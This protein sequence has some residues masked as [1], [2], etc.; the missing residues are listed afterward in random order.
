MVARFQYKKT[1]YYATIGYILAI[2]TFRISDVIIAYHKGLKMVTSNSSGKSGHQSPPIVARLKEETKDCHSRIEALP[3]FNALSEHKLPLECYVNQLRALAVVHGVFETEIGSS[4]DNR[5]TAI[6]DDGLKKL[7][8][9]VQDLKFFESRVVSDTSRS[10]DAALA[11][12]GDIRLRGIENPVTLLGY[13]Y[14]FEGSTLGNSMH[15]SDIVATYQL[16]DLDG[17]CYYSSYQDQVPLHWN[18]FS[19]K[20]NKTLEDSSLHDQIVESVRKAF[21]GLEALHKALYPIDVKVKAYHATRINPEAGNHPI[22]EDER[23]I[24]AALKASKRGWSEFSYYEQRYGG[25]G[26]RFSDSD[27]CWLVTLTRLDP[28]SLQKQI[29][30]LGRVLSTRGMPLIMLECTLKFLHEEL[31]KAVP[32]QKITYDKLLMAADMLRKLRINIMP[33]KDFEA[34]SREFDQAVGSKLARKYINTG[35]LLVASVIDE[36]NGIAGAVAALQGWLTDS[37]RFPENWIQAVNSTIKKA[38]HRSS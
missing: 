20:M 1:N 31:V 34:L 17:C 37:L 4:E 23:E 2:F 3:Y 13:L 12:T 16:N 8:L 36:K 30:W 24:Q 15:K 10:I 38:N 25:R 29:E 28:E 19:E 9:L 5:I 27:T 32:A 26:K 6:W 33:E 7:P 35:K 14:V 21:S 18:Q 11:M 22:P